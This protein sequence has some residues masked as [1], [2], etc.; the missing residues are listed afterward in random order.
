MT[1]F[2]CCVALHTPP[3]P[4]ELPPGQGGQQ[5]QEVAW[6]Y[7]RWQRPLWGVCEN[8]TLLGLI[9]CSFYVQ[10]GLV[11]Q[12]QQGVWIVF[13]TWEFRQI[14]TSQPLGE[15]AYFVMKTLS[16]TPP[17]PLYRW[18]AEDLNFFVSL[19]LGVNV[20][21]LLNK[22]LQNWTCVFFVQ[23]LDISQIHQ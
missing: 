11:F 6:H 9:Y 1:N 8:K 20:T 7:C 18:K 12:C 19:V 5:W 22:K 3:H 16:Q 10:I 14:H 4:F 21:S 2:S 15:N 23:I 13:C 17:K